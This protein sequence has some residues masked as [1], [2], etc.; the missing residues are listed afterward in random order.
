[1]NTSISHS[2]RV[3]REQLADYSSELL[4]QRLEKVLDRAGDGPAAAD[5][6]CERIEKMVALFLGADPARGLARRLKQALR[7]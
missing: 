4:L 2:K 6:A 5:A 7:G 3:L 1:M